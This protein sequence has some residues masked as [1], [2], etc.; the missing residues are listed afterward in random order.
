MQVSAGIRLRYVIRKEKRPL[1]KSLVCSVLNGSHT[2]FAC[3]CFHDWERN[4]GNVGKAISLYLE[5]I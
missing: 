1:D 5:I 3:I 2:D 4:G